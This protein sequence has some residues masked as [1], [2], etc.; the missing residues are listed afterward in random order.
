MSEGVFQ[1][2]FEL[3]PVL[4]QISGHHVDKFLDGFRAVVREC[5]DNIF[6]RGVGVGA[7]GEDFVLPDELGFVRSSEDWGAHGA[8]E[9]H[10]LLFL[11]DGEGQGLDEL[12][13]IVCMIG[14]GVGPRSRAGGGSGVA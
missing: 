9:C 8:R 12:P 4:P 14:Q 3:H 6:C 11:R 2:L 5:C 7:R 10:L 13:V 1:C